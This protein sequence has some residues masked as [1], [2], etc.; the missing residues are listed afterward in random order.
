MYLTVDEIQDQRGFDQKKI[1]PIF[2][3]QNKFSVE[4]IIYFFFGSPLHATG[5]AVGP[6]LEGKSV[7]MRRDQVPAKNFAD[8]E[9]GSYSQNQTKISK[10]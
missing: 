1:T 10:I 5:W 4:K 3:T 8:I 7:K 2:N 6:D 9:F